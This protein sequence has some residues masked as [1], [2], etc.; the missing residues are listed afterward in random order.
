MR[1]AGAAPAWGGSVGGSFCSV[2]WGCRS[3]R[4]L[5]SRSTPVREALGAL[6]HATTGAARSRAARRAK[7]I[8]DFLGKG[9][10]VWRRVAHMLAQATPLASFHPHIL[11]GRPFR[12]AN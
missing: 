12:I 6:V 7:R 8:G 2:F 5:R 10:R 1:P 11:L 4:A 3:R 9:R